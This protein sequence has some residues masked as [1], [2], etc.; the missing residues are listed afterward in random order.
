MIS[1]DTV[2]PADAHAIAKAS[3][4]LRRGGLV[5][6]PTETVYG[7]GADASNDQAVTSIFAAKQRP[8]FNPL[9]V[10]VRDLEHAGS[11][12]SLNIIAREL[13]DAFWPGPLTL[14]LP[15]CEG[16]PVSFLAS[17]GLD[18]IAVRV[19]AHPV[20]RQLLVA[21]G[22]ALAAPS[23]NPSGSISATS[24]AHVAAELGDRVEMIL[25]A[26]PTS[27]GIES[28][29]IGFEREKP[30]LLRAG[31]LSRER[32]EALV[33]RLEAPVEGGVCSPGQLKRHYAPRTPI[34]LDAHDVSSGEALLAF[35]GATPAG[36]RFERNLS[37]SADLAE[38]AANLFAMMRELDAAGYS[39]IAVMPIPE[40]GLGEAI[41]DRL[42]RAATPEED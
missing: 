12:V 41:N 29:V 40:H 15:R 2:S 39:G 4:I 25:D 16:S 30:V 17:A 26:G 37:P 27:L 11:L 6:F 10:H 36:A 13:A 9:I 34:R 23:A 22:L 42:R 28:T 35:G 33:G 1:T 32:I 14:V 20:A 18:T 3:E 8:R 19:P 38:A 5:A 7:L 24:A 31:A 21:S